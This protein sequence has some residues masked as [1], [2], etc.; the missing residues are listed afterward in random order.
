MVEYPLEENKHR[1]LSVIINKL[2]FQSDSVTDLRPT[3]G[4]VSEQT[5]S[6]TLFKVI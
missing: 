6:E 2:L 1:A 3:V 4:Y 5:T